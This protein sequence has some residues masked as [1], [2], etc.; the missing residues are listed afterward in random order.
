MEQLIR[1]SLAGRRF[2]LMGFAAS[3]GDTISSALG[4]MGGMGHV[5]RAAPSIPGLNCFSPFDACFIN[6]SVSAADEPAPIEMLTGTRKP[7]VIVAS[8]EDLV[9]RF[10]A[11]IADLN[12]EFVLRP[13]NDRDLLLRAFRVL[14]FVDSVETIETPVRNGARCILVADDDAAT[15][16]LIST[17]L[18]HFKFACEVARNGEEALEL[19]RKMRPQ[20][21]LLDIQMPRMDGFQALTALRSD[22]ATRNTPVIL[23]TQRQTEADVIKGFSL[24]AADYV[25]KPFRSGELM[26]R[27]NCALREPE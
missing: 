19:A 25:T 12:R 21:V 5:V 9:K 27:I 1:K 17:I 6:A 20:L 16:V 7:A 26:A 4:S 22:M 14:R 15:V 23:L 24:G 8:F 11:A 10:P 2:A 13:Y 18:K 3:E